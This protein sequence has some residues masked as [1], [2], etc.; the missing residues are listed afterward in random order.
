MQLGLDGGYLVL[1]DL[2]AIRDN[3]RRDSSQ[4][5]LRVRA[6]NGFVFRVWGEWCMLETRLDHPLLLI[7]SPEHS[8]GQVCPPPLPQP[9]FVLGRLFLYEVD[10]T[11]EPRARP[12]PAPPSCPH[13]VWFEE[14]EFWANSLRFGGQ[15][16]PPFMT[17]NSPS[18][19]LLSIRAARHLHTR[20]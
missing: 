2:P 17:D 4:R 15:A 16:Q 3:I 13:C 7:T 18:Q 9:L 6:V 8:P 5:L 14:F 20:C 12:P 1:D 10:H 11:G 19:I